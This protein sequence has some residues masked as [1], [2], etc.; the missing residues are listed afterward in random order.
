[1][2]NLSSF[3][4]GLE[5]GNPLISTIERLHLYSGTY[6]EEPPYSVLITGTGWWTLLE[7]PHQPYKH[8]NGATMFMLH[9]EM[10][11]GSLIG[12][13]FIRNMKGNLSLLSRV[14][15]VSLGDIAN[16]N[17]TIRCG[18]E[19]EN[20]M[21]VRSP[22]WRELKAIPHILFNLPNLQHICQS[23]AYG[24]L[25]LRPG[26]YR[27]A[28]PPKVFNYHR[29]LSR[30]HCV[31]SG[32]M[33]PI[34][35]GSINRYFCGCLHAVRLAPLDPFGM[36]QDIERIGTLL[37]WVC[38][39]P[40]DLTNLGYGPRGPKV[41]V[42]LG[43]TKIELYDFIRFSADVPN[44]PP[45]QRVYR[46]CTELACRP[47]ASLAAFQHL[48]TM[49]LPDEWRGRVILKNREEAPPCTACGLDV[50]EQWKHTIESEGLGD[51]K[52]EPCKVVHPWE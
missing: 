48:L 6:R 5:S 19:T 45:Q 34:I 14:N 51:G 24:P 29:K 20:G 39:T 27:V 2:G 35:L 22:L 47:A 50:K 8:T 42:G 21:L 18:P 30:R 33:G 10:Y 1:M 52:I 4:S 44:E 3:L 7:T 23:T 12:Y 31:C 13:H 9:E 38:S 46:D 15:V 26:T 37:T 49:S 36:S 40:I 17:W 41:P 25:A 43:D 16:L 32:D 28:N 11:I